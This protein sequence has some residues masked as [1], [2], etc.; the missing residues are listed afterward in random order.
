MK[1]RQIMIRMGIIS[2]FFILSAAIVVYA[3]AYANF[4]IGMAI[5]LLFISLIVAIV[6]LVRD[7]VYLFRNTSPE[8]T[9]RLAILGMPGAGKTVYCTVLFDTL[10]KKTRSGEPYC[11]SDG[12]HIRLGDKYNKATIKRVNEDYERLENRSLP[13]E[14]R[15][16]KAT[17][18]KAY[19]SY[20]AE[21]KIGTLKQF[22][23]PIKYF[24]EINDHAGQPSGK[25]QE[26]LTSRKLYF[27]RQSFRDIKRS[28][29]FIIMICLDM[30]YKKDYW[31][32]TE[33]IGKF[34]ELFKSTIQN[35]QSE[36]DFKDSDFNGDGKMCFPVAIVFLKSD[37]TC[38]DASSLDDEYVDKS[39]KTEDNTK[40]KF[41]GLISFCKDR[42]QHVDSF[43]VTS[44]GCRNISKVPLEHKNLI[45][46]FLWI[47]EKHV[48]GDR[49]LSR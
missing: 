14:E 47:I 19:V 18:E 1:I 24:L 44:T 22:S 9:L 35:M 17:N 43:F 12:R 3:L 48:D 38:E 37:I 34:E 36:R 26:L 13:L 15:W 46:P 21:L 6:L 31:N 2:F 7:F 39:E 49:K 29:G 11:L 32:N 27:K 10:S 45:D 30:L 42:F 28:H 40:E 23:N 4:E 33:I 41:L 20:R 25:V 8:D 16:P 5:R